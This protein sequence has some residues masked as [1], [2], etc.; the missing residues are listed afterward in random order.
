[1]KRVLGGGAAVAVAGAVAVIALGGEEAP[2]TEAPA[3]QRETVAV[4]R[5]D[6][7]DRESLAGTLGYADPGVLGAGVAGTLTGIRAAGTVITR[8]HSFYDIDGAPA[9]FLFYGELPVWRD[10]APGMTD[11]EDVRQLERN[12]RALGYDAGTVD[13]DWDWETTAAVK[14]FQADRGLTKD[15]TLTRGEVVFR[16]GATRMGEAKAEVGDTVGGGRPLAELSSTGR[17]VVVELDARRQQLARRG[18]EVTVELPTGE[19]AKGRVSSVGTVASKAGEDSAPT[20][21]VTIALRGRGDALDQAPVDVGFAVERRRDALAV[22]VKALL[23]VQGGG[24]A[25]ELPDGRKVPVE[26]GLYA[27][28]LVEVTGDGLREGMKVV[29]AR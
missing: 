23:A 24:Y 9:A 18:D 3:V 25:L 19:T 7:V 17:E 20:V 15:G 5:S 6:L 13:D 27:D 2:A 10:F 29:T 28:D 14:A 1:M 21:D 8:G 26:T 12:L 22:P 11:G 4:E 16:P